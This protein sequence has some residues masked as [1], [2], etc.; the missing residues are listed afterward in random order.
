MCAGAT[1]TLTDCSNAKSAKLLTVIHIAISGWRAMCLPKL[2]GFASVVLPTDDLISS[3]IVFMNS[4]TDS[5]F[6]QHVGIII[7]L[8]LIW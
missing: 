5:P 8:L 7:A 2:A 1:T 6:E 4:V 3:E